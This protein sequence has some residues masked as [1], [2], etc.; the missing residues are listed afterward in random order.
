MVYMQEVG[1]WLRVA[2]KKVAMLVGL[3]GIMRYLSRRDAGLCV[4]YQTD[5]PFFQI[6]Q[7]CCLGIGSSGRM[8]RVRGGGSVIGLARSGPIE[9]KSALMWHP[10]NLEKHRS[11]R[12]HGRTWELNGVATCKGMHV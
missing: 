10:P 9:A 7:H 3:R 6:A 5:L 4:P 12:T 11:M 1:K 8:H 2:G